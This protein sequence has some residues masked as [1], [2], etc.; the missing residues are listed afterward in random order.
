MRPRGPCWWEKDVDN[1]GR[2]GVLATCNAGGAG[3]WTAEHAAFLGGRRVY[4]TRDNDDSGLRHI[5][6]VAHSLH[7]NAE[8]VRIVELPGLPAKGEHFARASGGAESGN[9][10]VQASPENRGAQAAQKAAQ[11]AHAAGGEESQTKRRPR[12]KSRS[13]LGT[14]LSG[15]I[16]QT[17]GMEDKG[18]E[19]SAQV[20]GKR[21]NSQSR[22]AQSGAVGARVEIAAGIDANLVAVIQA[23]PEL[24][25]A[26]RVGILALIR[27]F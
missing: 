20:P 10:G 26:I 27:A 9:E 3:K 13:L 7:G 2:I 25:E 4:A 18:L 21:P 23:W 17:P 12:K 11:Q 1:L 5:E 24:P 19:P 8:W 16:L 22:G 15:A 14:A 6:Q